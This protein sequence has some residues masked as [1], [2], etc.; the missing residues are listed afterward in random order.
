HSDQPIYLEK[1]ELFLPQRK[2][3]RGREPK[4]LKA[5]VQSIKVAEYC[6][7][8]QSNEWQKIKVRNTA[9]GTLTSLY[10]FVRVFV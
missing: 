10:H 5:S 2:S 3:L 8:L 4:R 6:K 1:P 7:N 9:K